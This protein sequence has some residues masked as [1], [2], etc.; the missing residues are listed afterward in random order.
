MES[1]LQ[2]QSTEQEQTGKPNLT[3]I[4]SQM[5]LDFERRSGLSFDDVRVHY[6][7][8]KPARFFAHAY[9]FGTQVHIGPGQERH[10][11]HELGH[12]AQQKWGMVRPT[13]SINGIPA[14]EN[15]GLERN[16]DRLEGLRAETSAIQNPS[17]ILQRMGAVSLAEMLELSG[18]SVSALPEDIQKLLRDYDKLYDDTEKRMDFKQQLR[19][20][21]AL[22]DAI[23]QVPESS[24]SRSMTAIVK[25]EM[26]I[27]KKQETV[28]WDSIQKEL[29]AK[30]LEYKALETCI[31][32]LIANSG[33]DFASALQKKN[34]EIKKRNL[35]KEI[36]EL[37]GLRTISRQ[38]DPY[39]FMDTGVEWKHRQYEK[40]YKKTGQWVDQLS[41]ANLRHLQEAEV[42]KGA[43]TR[44]ARNIPGYT[45]FY[46][47]IKNLLTDRTILSHYSSQPDI[48]VLLSKEYAVSS[49][50]S[51]GEDHSDKKM[52]QDLHNTGFVFFFLERD[53][54]E[55]RQ[56]TRFG[57][58]RYVITKPQKILSR[59]WAMLAD[60]ITA[61][62]RFCPKMIVKANSPAN[63]DRRDKQMQ[64]GTGR[65]DTTMT[66]LPSNIT[67]QLERFNNILKGDHI[68]DGLAHSAAQQLYALY[69]VDCDI[70]MSFEQIRIK[71]DDD[72]LDIVLRLF[73]VQIMVPKAVIPE[74]MDERTSASGS[75]AQNP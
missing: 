24:M 70:A 53:N 32:D 67:I 16:A 55:P 62:S 33:G 17:G 25:S 60:F 57:T 14:A 68:I 45:E 66:Y 38:M 64:A 48:P 6:H 13:A 47:R 31:T 7:S 42:T 30:T 36:D 35:E 52:E 12:V 44:K 10:L 59:S 26:Q 46:T 73:E 5:K 2:Q 54:A 74:R 63:Q 22:G 8:D 18:H 29:D 21:Q 41:A 4:P 15:P 20:L 51:L 58:Y 23:A 43:Y 3:G 11:P 61:Y 39:E 65:L 75:Q 19:I 1:K 50:I 40:Y 49:C 71:N 34:L 37:K 56:N 27:I 69:N 9:T 72:L 28:D